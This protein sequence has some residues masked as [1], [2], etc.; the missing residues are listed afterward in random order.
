M[1]AIFSDAMEISNRAAAPLGS[2]HFA[3]SVLTS[4]AELVGPP[5]FPDDSRRRG[6]R[7]WPNSSH[8]KLNSLLQNR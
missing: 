1:P 3:F 4:V 7:I 8:R 2:Q 5:K 6:F